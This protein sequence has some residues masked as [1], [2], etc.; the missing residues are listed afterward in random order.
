MDH[1]RLAKISGRSLT[2]DDKG[3]SYIPKASDMPMTP[4][5][6]FLIILKSI[7]NYTFLFTANTVD[8]QQHWNLVKCCGVLWRI[9]ISWKV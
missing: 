6:L 9:G 8:I 5:K 7:V 4:Q 1:E 2:F 3:L